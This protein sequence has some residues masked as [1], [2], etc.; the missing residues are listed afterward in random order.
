[1]TDTSDSSATAAPRPASARPRRTIVITGVGRAGQMGEALADAFA[2]DGAALALLDRDADEVAGRAE[3]LR[4][5]GAFATAHPCDL[6]NPDAVAAAVRDVTTAHGDR[7]DA[8]VLA[9]GG[10]AMSG[11][12]ADS[13]PDD[14]HLQFAIN[15]TTAYVATRSFL[16]LVRNARGALC[17]FASAAV[18]PDGGSAGI[19]AYAAA[20]SGV[21]SLMRTVAAEERESGVRA[22]AVAPT[23]IRT[24]ANTADMGD[25][26]DYVEREELAGMVL[27]LCS[28]EARRVTG[29]V[30][31]AG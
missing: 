12:V 5:R 11:P 3:T 9:A 20:K 21:L 22:N 31:R 23:S 28:E 29:Q 14:W 27:W 18:L 26:A 15:L 10:F 25:D 16:P 19:A 30:V 8:L 7:V 6:T 1:M 4:T 24:A 2:R 13:N 17:Y